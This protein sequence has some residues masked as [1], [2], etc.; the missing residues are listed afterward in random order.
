MGLTCDEAERELADLGEVNH[1]DIGWLVS[2]NLATLDQVP[3][4]CRSLFFSH[5]QVDVPTYD[6]YL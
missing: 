6:M 3:P 1:Q 5:W 4:S 2:D